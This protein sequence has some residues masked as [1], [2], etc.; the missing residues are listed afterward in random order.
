MLAQSPYNQEKPT[1]STPSLTV[2]LRNSDG[3]IDLAAP[4]TIANGFQIRVTDPDRNIDTTARDVPHTAALNTGT[5]STNI[6]DNSANPGGGDTQVAYE[7]SGLRFT[8]TGA[9]AGNITI[10]ST[11]TFTANPGT[12]TD[13]DITVSTP[14]E[15]TGV[16][17]G[18]I[19]KSITGTGTTRTVTITIPFSTTAAVTNVKLDDTAANK[20]TVTVGGIDNSTTLSSVTTTATILT[21]GINLRINGVG[22]P[23]VFKETDDNTNIFLPDLAG[24]KIQIVP[25]TTL[26]GVSIAGVIEFKDAN[27]NNAYDSG[28]ER[29][30]LGS[31]NKIYVLASAIKDDP[32]LTISYIDP[33][34]D[35]SGPKEFKIVRKIQHFAGSISTTTTSDTDCTTY[36][37]I[38][39]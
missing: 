16:T 39:S 6:T 5:P 17:Y 21:S 19:S 4:L 15:P 11:L 23:V 10:I 2:Q 28:E 14:T 30:V 27:N 8:T 34:A 9:T 22:I 18:T 31:D 38:W 20:I 26:S 37:S 1:T 13:A 24:N 12:I 29:I 3:S 33:Q 36:N 7:V 35:P 32:D 25:R